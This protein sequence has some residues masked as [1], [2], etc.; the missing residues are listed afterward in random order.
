MASRP[1]TFLA[2]DEDR[3]LSLAAVYGKVDWTR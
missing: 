3:V 2:Q 1:N